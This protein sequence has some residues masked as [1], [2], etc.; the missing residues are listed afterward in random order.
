M[1]KLTLRCAI[2]TRKSSEEGLEQGFNS[3]DAQREAC[4]AFVLSQQ[5]EGWKL[6]PTFYDDGGY[7]GGNMDRPALKQLLCDIDQKKINVVVVYK[8]D[9]LTRSLA[10]FAKIVEQFDAKGISF[11]S[12]TQQFNTTSSMGRLT[13]NVLLSFAQFEREVTG[14]RIRDKIAASK[15]KGMWMGGTPPTGYI[16][17]ERTLEIEPQGAA[18][19]K[20][21][22]ERYLVIGDVRRLK[23]NLD[24]Q[25]IRSPVSTSSTGRH[26]GGTLL[27]R[28]QLYRLLS[29]PI[30]LGKIVHKDQIFPGQHLAIISQELWDQV[31]A[32]L[33]SNLQGH[34]LR[35]STPSD[36]LLTRLVFDDAGHRLVPSHSQKHSKRYRYYLSKPLVTQSRSDAPKGLRIPA[37]D[38]EKVV[39][40][41]LGQWLRD[42][43]A[44]IDTLSIN[45][46]HMQSFAE[47]TLGIADQLQVANGQRYALVHQLV[48]KVIVSTNEIELEINP[49][50]LRQSCET[51]DDQ[52]NSQTHQPIRITT[53]IQINRCGFAMRLIIDGNQTVGQ[54]LDQR[55]IASIRKAQDWLGQLTS[56]KTLSLGEIAN[57]EGVTTTHVTNII[58]RAFL[59]PDIVRLILNGTQPATL[60]SDSLKRML[61]LP[62]DWEEQRNVLG[63]K[64]I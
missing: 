17:K 30:Y 52:L 4:E 41:E 29:N 36:S 45:A 57:A 54:A 34:K 13:L 46:Q 59:A 58:N 7:S 47:H 24:R 2:Y 51:L 8:V 27:G 60:T 10:D 48:N 23:L 3:L 44:L 33:S 63:I 43:N 1:T 37:D 49:N 20:L 55:L 35:Q 26:Y 28:G 5:H 11:V 9:R 64:P 22:Y 21:I 14:E 50:R 15:A 19:I 56:G 42:T 38:L 62:L 12:V 39:I 6:I 16:P 25:G 31:Q 18:L 53:P 32:K 61:P 40:E